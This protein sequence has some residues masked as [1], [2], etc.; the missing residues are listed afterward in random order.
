MLRAKQTADIVAAKCNASIMLRTDLQ[1]RSFGKL[2]GLTREEIDQT[3]PE[4]GA[5][6]RQRIRWDFSVLENDDYK[7]ETIHMTQ[8]R[9]FNGIKDIAHKCAEAI[10]AI[11]THGAAINSFS[12][13]SAHQTSLIALKMEKS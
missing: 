6:L 13:V 4:V 7:I 8:E 12:I 1:E 9:L 2:E 10:I 5:L 11:S 3:Y